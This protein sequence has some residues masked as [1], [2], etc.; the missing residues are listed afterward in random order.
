MSVYLSGP[1]KVLRR[2]RNLI[3]K[4]IKKTRLLVS[5][6]KRFCVSSAI[7]SE[8]LLLKEKSQLRFKKKMSPKHYI[9]VT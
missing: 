8:K 5:V 6:L 1:I 3:Y 9:S 2:L 4:E 7:E